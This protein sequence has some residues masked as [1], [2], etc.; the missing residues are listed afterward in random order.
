MNIKNIGSVLIISISALS[1]TSCESKAATGI[2]AGGATGAAIGGIAG[3]GT[4][5]A[6]GAGAG[7]VAG[8]L[9]GAA[10]DAQDKRNLEKENARAAKRVEKGQQLS[11]DDVIAMHKAGISDDKIIDILK[12]SDSR[13][14]LTTKDIDK[15]QRAGVSNSVINYMMRT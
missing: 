15:M 12:A 3:G 4:G 8:G 6:I 14:Y 7:A 9:I 10:L 13:F 1:L 5:A 2:F 11:V